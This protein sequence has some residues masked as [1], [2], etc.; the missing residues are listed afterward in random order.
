VVDDDGRV[1]VDPCEEAVVDAGRLVAV[2]DGRL[3]VD[4][5]ASVEA[6]VPVEEAAWAVGAEFDLAQTMPAA[7]PT[8]VMSTTSTSCSRW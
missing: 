3:V 4:A 2:D 1:V 5:G 7:A 6:E 8:R